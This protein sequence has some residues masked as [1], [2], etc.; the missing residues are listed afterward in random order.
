MVCRSHFG[1]VDPDSRA[2]GAGPGPCGGARIRA[3]VCLLF[4]VF[5]GGLHNDVAMAVNTVGRQT[6]VQV[7]PCVRPLAGPSSGS[8]PAGTCWRA[9]FER[10]SDT[11]LP[12]VS[13]KTHFTPRSSC[14]WVM[15][16]SFMNNPEL[17]KSAF[18][19]SGV[20]CVVL[21]RF[22]FTRLFQHTSLWV[23]LC[24]VCVGLAPACLPDWV[25]SM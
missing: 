20:W 17:F 5:I 7:N 24:F 19:L 10:V 15:C 13:C 16:A 2:C 11:L 18:Y 12:S 21:L 6:P 8:V 4:C 25:I 22:C 9:I 23:R 3:A 1:F 14:C